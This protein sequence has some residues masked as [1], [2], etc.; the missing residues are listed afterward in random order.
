M[1][2]RSGGGTAEI[3]HVRQMSDFPDDAIEATKDFAPRPVGWRPH[4]SSLV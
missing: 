2:H 4:G 1:G 3:R